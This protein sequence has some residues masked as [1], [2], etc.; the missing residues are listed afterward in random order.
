MPEL[1]PAV[2]SDEQRRRLSRRSFLRVGLG[3]GLAVPVASG[4]LAAC[5]APP[6]TAAPAATQAAPAA[7]AAAAAAPTA[8]AQVAP[9]VAS[10]ST[11]KVSILG[12]QMT[13]DEVAAGLK[14]E[15]EVNV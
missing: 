6:P 11:F 13:K 4:L 12:K 7:T 14:A 10:G 5:S 3:F 9:T 2:D 8:A 1:L 15:G